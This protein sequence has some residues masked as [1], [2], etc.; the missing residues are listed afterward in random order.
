MLDHLVNRPSWSKIAWSELEENILL[1]LCSEILAQ[2]PLYLTDE[3]QLATIYVDQLL[4]KNYKIII[5][6]QL[7]DDPTRQY[8]RIYSDE[9]KYKRML[10]AEFE[11]SIAE[12]G[13]GRF[14]PEI[15]VALARQV[16][17]K[18]E[19]IERLVKTLAIICGELFIM[20]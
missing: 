9:L 7:F 13:L 5:D 10:I 19:L 18:E 8:L 11:K 1:S 2:L 14:G 16:Q 20:A 17:E 12:G 4:H 3:E 6:K 15:Q